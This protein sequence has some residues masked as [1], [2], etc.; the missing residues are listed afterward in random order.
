[1]DSRS[2]GDVFFVLILRLVDIYFS[3]SQQREG[4]V[5]ICCILIDCII[6]SD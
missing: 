2:P 4:I 3:D 6:L 5:P 1:M